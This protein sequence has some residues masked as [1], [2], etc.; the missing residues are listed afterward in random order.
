[1]LIQ[2]QHGK[3]KHKAPGIVGKDRILPG[4]NHAG[5]G[6]SAAMAGASA[7]RPS[8]EENGFLVLL[9]TRYKLNF[10]WLL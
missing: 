8:Q 3:A 4:K 7:I 10:Y 1:M 5:Q 9:I 6:K 2:L